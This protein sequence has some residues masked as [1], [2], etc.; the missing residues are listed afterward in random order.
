MHCMFQKNFWGLIVFWWYWKNKNFLTNFK[1]DFFSKDQIN[2][3]L[4]YSISETKKMWAFRRYQSQAQAIILVL[5]R[6]LSSV[7]CRKILVL[8]IWYLCTSKDY[9]SGCSKILVKLDGQK[10]TLIIDQFFKSILLTVDGHIELALF[11]N[12]KKCLCKQLRLCR[13]FLNPWRFFRCFPRTL[14]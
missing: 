5:S 3:I 14:N 7:N 9:M 13:A 12:E 2:K 11:R 8:Q 1:I 4:K 10:S 6:L